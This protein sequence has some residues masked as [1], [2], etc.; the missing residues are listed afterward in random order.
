MKKKKKIRLIKAFA[1]DMGPTYWFTLED[2][3]N[4]TPFPGLEL[5][6]GNLTEVVKTVSYDPMFDMFTVTMEP[7]FVD[8]K[9]KP[10]QEKAL[11][12]TL[13]GWKEPEKALP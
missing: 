13:R 11:P 6:W 1:Y 5:T 7:D 3:W 10:I 9:D 4:F 12:Y 8:R 2:E